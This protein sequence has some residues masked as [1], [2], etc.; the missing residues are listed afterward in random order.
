MGAGNNMTRLARTSRPLAGQVAPVSKFWITRDRYE[1][2][3]SYSI[4]SI[5]PALD[6]DGHWARVD[7][8]RTGTD[9]RQICSAKVAEAVLGRTLPLG[10]KIGPIV[11]LFNPT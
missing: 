7:P 10:R 8:K 9:V 6:R 2:L 11:G 5:E 4:W 3:L 1:N